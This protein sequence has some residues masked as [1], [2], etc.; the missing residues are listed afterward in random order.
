MEEVVREVVIDLRDLADEDRSA[1]GLA[2]EAVPEVARDGDAL[3][4]REP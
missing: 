2:I 1:A 4:G 3:A